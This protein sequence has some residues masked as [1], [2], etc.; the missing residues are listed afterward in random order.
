MNSQD[1][2]VKKTSKVQRNKDYIRDVPGKTP[3]LKHH[4]SEHYQIGLLDRRSA[5]VTMRVC[6]AAAFPARGIRYRIN[7]KMAP[8]D[9][10]PSSRR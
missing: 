8:E 10:W 7:R 3:P 5:Q 4:A 2:E 6:S 1:D 9:T